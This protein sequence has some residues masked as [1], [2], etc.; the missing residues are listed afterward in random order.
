MVSK[1][2]SRP[3]SVDQKPGSKCERLRNVFR[4]KKKLIATQEISQTAESNKISN[5]R[6]HQLLLVK[7]LTS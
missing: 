4:R 2:S 3:V 5:V 6:C 1:N 7:I